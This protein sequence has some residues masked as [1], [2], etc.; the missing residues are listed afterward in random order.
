MI[1]ER[2]DLTNIQKFHY[3]KSSVRGEAQ[4]L[5]VHL[6]ITH[7]NY[8]T[9][10]NLLKS[11]FENKRIIVQQHVNTTAGNKGIA[12]VPKTT[13]RWA[14]DQFKY[15]AKFRRRLQFRP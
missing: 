13:V 12:S 15:I 2:N 5:I 10:Y 11:R 4:K 14:F 9:A 8:I 6:A 3:L 1:H 7:D